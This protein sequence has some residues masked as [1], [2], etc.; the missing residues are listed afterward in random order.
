MLWKVRGP[1]GYEE[2]I[3]EGWVRIIKAL[4]LDDFR[5]LEEGHQVKHWSGKVYDFGYIGQTGRVICYKPG[6]R[7]M[8]DSFAFLP[9]DLEIAYDSPG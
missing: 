1:D 7:N 3:Q 8:Q 5:N 6:E 2:W 4:T 9:E